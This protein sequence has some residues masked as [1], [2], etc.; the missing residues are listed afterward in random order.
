MLPEI[1]D[2]LQSVTYSLSVLSKVD[3]LCD[4]V[5]AICDQA[6]TRCDQVSLNVTRGI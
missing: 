6:V 4:Q 3:Y 5:V 1:L 2:K